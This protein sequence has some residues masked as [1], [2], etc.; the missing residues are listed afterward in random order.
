ML[1]PFLVGVLGAQAAPLQIRQAS[2][3]DLTI[4][5]VGPPA[6]PL[7]SVSSRPDLRCGGISGGMRG[8]VLGA[9][10]Q[11]AALAEALESTFYTQ[12]LERFTADDFTQAGLDGQAVIEQ[13]TQVPKSPKSPI[14]ADQTTCRD[15][16]YTPRVG[17][18]R[19]TGYRHRLTCRLCHQAKV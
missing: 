9:D 19:E 5:K 6:S 17:P 1:I 2:S 7:P 15:L 18:V 13:I 4:V 8:T 16:C 12:A 3:P 14:P 10:R 11:F